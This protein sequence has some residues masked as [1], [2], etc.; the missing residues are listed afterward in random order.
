MPTI[1]QSRS[2]RGS[3]VTSTTGTFRNTPTAGNMVAVLVGGWR[4]GGF[5]ASSV[6]D[7]Q[8]N[9]YTK[10]AEPATAGNNSRCS[11]WTAENIAASGTFTVTVTSSAASS[12]IEASIIEIA[13]A[14][15]SSSTDITATANA[16]ATSTDANVTGGGAIAQ[17]NELWLS[18]CT[19]AIG[20]DVDV[21]LETPTGTGTWYNIRRNQSHNLSV[22][23][24]ADYYVSSAVT[25]P[26]VQYSHDATTGSAGW[27][28]AL[29][30]I[31]GT[32]EAAT[33]IEPPPLSANGAL[34]EM[35]GFDDVDT[36]TL[37]HIALSNTGNTVEST[38]GARN[39]GRLRMTSATTPR[40]IVQLKNKTSCQLVM[41]SFWIKIDTLT[42][43]S[44]DTWNNSVAVAWVKTS[45]ASPG[46]L[47]H[48]GVNADRKLYWMSVNQG[49]Q[50]LSPTQLTL[51]QEYYVECRVDFSDT[52]ADGN[53]AFYINGVLDSSAVGVQTSANSNFIITGEVEV[54]RGATPGGTI[55]ISV[56]D[57]AFWETGSVGGNTWV[58]GPFC[59][60][61]ND[62]DK[63]PHI[64]TFFPTSDVSTTNWTA[65]TGANHYALVDEVIP[66]T[67]DYSSTTTLN[68]V[69]RMGVT[70][71]G[72]DNGTIAAV[73]HRV[74]ANYGG[75]STLEVGATDTVNAVDV[76]ESTGSQASGARILRLASAGK[77][78]LTRQWTY[79]EVVGAQPYVKPTVIAGTLT[80]Y[81]SDLLVLAYG[82]A[83]ITT[84][85]PIWA[86][87]NS[88]RSRQHV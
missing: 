11:I 33:W 84:R 41:L 2:I 61:D 42:G 71:S 12:Y 74:S 50:L 37:T 8:G 26:A 58:D 13:G 66:D 76:A 65:S 68:A 77:S 43:I 78:P 47:A 72:M 85:V 17:A 36:S 35:Y 55:D 64:Y 18:C 22:G 70:V 44:A 31:K 45:A 30:T 21:N 63:W 82:D 20:S 4:S 40:T 28:C 14:A 59:P 38:G 56:D 25:T 34:M 87:T 62:P 6:T 53:V 88:L 46:Y 10:R 19:V 57:L 48:L 51:G 32:F 27:T 23:F 83:P 52:V 5:T 75:T 9:T 7:N 69:L 79:S 29:V 60:A 3:N 15:T 80:I 1:V 54:L 16:S 24:S 86:L 49:E 67:A 81:R 39:G 73:L